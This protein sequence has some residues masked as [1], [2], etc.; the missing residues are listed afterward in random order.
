MS[1]G[2]RRVGAGR[3]AGSAAGRILT[4]RGAARERIAELMVEGRDPLDVALAIAFDDSEPTP[5]RLQAAAVALPFVHPKLSAQTIQATSLHGNI[6][7]AAV[8]ASLLDRLDRLA[9]PASGPVIDVSSE[10]APAEAV[11]P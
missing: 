9:R 5:M 4:I 10:P 1:H 6:D 11:S 7:Q 3:K 8:L 2:G